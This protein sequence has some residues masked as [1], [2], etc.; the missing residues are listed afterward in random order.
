MEME[1]LYKTSTHV[2][3]IAQRKHC[4]SLLRIYKHREIKYYLKIIMENL[5]HK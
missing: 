5:N 1:T 2:L 4:K 3:G